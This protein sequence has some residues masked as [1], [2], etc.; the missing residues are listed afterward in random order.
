MVPQGMKYRL[1]KV[2]RA[3]GFVLW[4]IQRKAPFPHP[5]FWI[6][7][8]VDSFIE[9]E[10]ARFVLHKLRQGVPNEQRETVE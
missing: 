5:L 4:V 6:W 10:K 7:D 1:Q 3:S 8:Y 2:T 9:E